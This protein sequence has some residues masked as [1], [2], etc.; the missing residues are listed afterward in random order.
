MTRSISSIHP[1][2]RTLVVGGIGGVLISQGSTAFAATTCASSSER[3][4][5][6]L[7][8]RFLPSSID[9]ATKR[10][11]RILEA[12]N[13]DLRTLSKIGETRKMWSGPPAWPS[14]W[15]KAGTPGIRMHPEPPK[16]AVREKRIAG[17]GGTSIRLLVLHPPP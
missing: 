4:L 17:S 8:E 3:A 2:R 6:A 11:N 10:V 15:V 12:D 16:S 13:A 9:A 5:S 14:D 7:D 1:T